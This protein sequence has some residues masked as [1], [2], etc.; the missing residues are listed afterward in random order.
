MFINPRIAIERGWVTGIHNPEKQVQP[1][2]IDFTLDQLWEVHE[3]TV[4]II[5]EVGKEMR[6][7]SQMSP[8]P[9]RSDP[10]MCYWELY[11]RGI[12]DG[13]SDVYVDVPDGVAAMLVP[14]SSFTRN[15][16][17]L[18]SGLYDSG[19]KGHIGFVLHNGGGTARVFK[20]TRVGQII[21]VESENAL[22]YSGGYNHEEGTVA[23]H[24]EE[25]TWLHPK[26]TPQELSPDGADE[27]DA[28]RTGGRDDPMSGTGLFRDHSFTEDAE[29]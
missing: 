18:T 9:L 25:Q 10:D 23:P 27:R 6:H 19:F 28:K 8:V 13:L 22:V 4:F 14:R 7:R 15:G 26:I 20:G 21:F 11:S 1:N 29:E 12:Y 3:D 2:A 5:S 24:Q 16:F 17:L